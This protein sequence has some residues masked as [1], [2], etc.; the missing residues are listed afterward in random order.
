MHLSSTR[1]SK[2]VMATG[3]LTATSARDRNRHTS[4]LEQTFQKPGVVLPSASCGRHIYPPPI[5]ERV[6]QLSSAPKLGETYLCHHI[7]RSLCGYP[8]HLYHPLYRQTI[9]QLRGPSE[10]HAS[11]AAV[12]G[13]T[14]TSLSS[15][16]S[17][18]YRAYYW[19]LHLRE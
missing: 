2:V 9:S 19:D 10:L 15:T 1:A 16:G 18:L 8:L 6:H 11:K 14:H 7:S 4:L 13:V 12:G 17:A 5:L 3:I